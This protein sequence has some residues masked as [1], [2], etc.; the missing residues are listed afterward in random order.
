MSD[1]KFPIQIPSI[2]KIC[3]QHGR[4]VFLIVAIAYMLLV[5]AVRFRRATSMQAAFGPGKR[6]LSSM[7]RKEAF[8]IMTQLQELEFPSAM[9]KARTLALLKV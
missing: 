4:T 2:Y 6:S 1:L 8:D 7:T 9:A 3:E 5:R